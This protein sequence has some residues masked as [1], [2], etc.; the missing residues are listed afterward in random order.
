[1]RPAS[2]VLRRS[3][4]NTIA[5]WQL[6]LFRIGESILLLAIFIGVLIATIIPLAISAGLGNFRDLNAESAAPL[7]VSLIVR[8]WMLIIYLLV[9]VTVV[10]TIFVVI[11]SAIEAGSAAVYLE[12]ERAASISRSLSYERFSAFTLPSWLSGVKRGWWPVFW[13]YNI[14]W[15]IATIVIAAPALIAS[16]AAM[17]LAAGSAGLA[18]AAGCL[19]LLAT[20]ALAIG[21][22]IVTNVCVKKATVLAMAR[23]VPAREALREAWSSFRLDPA[24]QITVAVILLVVGIG[25]GAAISVM[26]S[27]FGFSDSLTWQ[28]VTSPLRILGSLVSAGF[29]AAMAGWLLA[30][31]ASMSA[32]QGASGNAGAGSDPATQ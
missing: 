14:A 3:F 19:G 26:S 31:F 29:S 21:V 23:N 10:L 8:H 32:E 6:L 22:S 20:L 7:I 30:A 16:L 15:T 28:L 27:P 25:G 17:V 24:R 1:M 11:H 12:A 18:I 13:I 5:N 4:N 9:A 2:E